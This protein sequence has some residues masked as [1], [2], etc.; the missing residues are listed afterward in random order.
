MR[1]QIYKGAGMSEIFGVT[2]NTLN[3]LGA[4]QK[5]NALFDTFA[6]STG[7][8]DIDGANSTT[9]AVATDEIVVGVDLSREAFIRPVAQQ[10]EGGGTFTTLPDDQFL[11]RHEKVG[12]YGF[13]EEGRVCLDARA[14]AGIIVG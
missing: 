1:E 9:F 10:S 6:S 2:I 4:S 13:L 5:Y 3:E 14:V 8:L 7:Y 11:A 12:F